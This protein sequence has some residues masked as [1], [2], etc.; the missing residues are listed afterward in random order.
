M[1]SGYSSPGH[2]RCFYCSQLYP[3]FAMSDTSPLFYCHPTV[4][5][6]LDHCRWH[7]LAAFKL[8]VH[9]VHL[10]RLR[11]GS[12]HVGCH[13]KPRTVFRLVLLCLSCTLHLFLDQYSGHIGLSHAGRLE[14]RLIP[15][16]TIEF[17]MY[18][19]YRVCHC[20][21]QECALHHIRFIYRIQWLAYHRWSL[22]CQRIRA[23]SRKALTPLV[24]QCFV[25]LWRWHYFWA[26]FD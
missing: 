1:I 26:I 24:V 4:A 8:H 12:Q 23:Q 15:N 11:S 25:A 21:P 18:H 7:F 6:D 2:R 22:G 3:M 16:G 10:L 5:L 17:G 20:W 13:S 14:W 9:D 19:S